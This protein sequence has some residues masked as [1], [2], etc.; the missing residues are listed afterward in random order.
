MT[1][2]MVM[3]PESTACGIALPKPRRRSVRAFTAIARLELAEVLRSRWLWFCLLTYAVLGSVF[4]LVGMRESSVLGFT[5]MGRVLLSFSHALVLVLPLLGLTASGLVVNRAREDGS[6]ELWFGHPVTRS[7]FFAAV[8]VV[9]YASLVLPL[10]LMLFGLGL[11]GRF[12][13]GQAIP[14]GFLVRT[15]AVSAAL[16]AVAVSFGLAVSTYVRNPAKAL[17]LLLLLWALGVALLDFAL[18]GL[19][20]QW[21]IKPLL[22]FALAALNP[23]QDARL[24][25][26]SGA[27]P[28]L[29]TLGPVGFF[30][31][32]HLGQAGLLALGLAWPCVLAAAAWFASLHRFRKGDLI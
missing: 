32:N 13:F 18:V 2:V 20:L 31:A 30:L 8:S 1:S 24:A 5:G 28:E 4:V 12:A 17:M 23:V 22:V 25:L 7:T 15:I 6:L 21:Q 19:M 29:G 14:W 26:L 3:E 11:V 9:R 27:E 16:L 10:V